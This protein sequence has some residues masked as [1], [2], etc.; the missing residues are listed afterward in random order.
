MWPETSRL[1]ILMFPLSHR[2]P[3]LAFRTLQTHVIDLLSFWITNQEITSTRVPGNS[4]PE[5]KWLPLFL[6]NVCSSGTTMMEASVGK[7][8]RQPWED[9]PLSLLITSVPLF[10][11]VPSLEGLAPTRLPSIKSHSSFKA[12]LKCHF[13][14]EAFPNLPVRINCLLLN[15]P[16]VLIISISWN[17][18][19]Y[20]L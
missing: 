1:P 18:L 19:W 11:L 5:A 8:R 16:G 12:Q 17:V 10:K 2:S 7:G 13:L 6:I 4:S 20:L 14:Q 15:V 9:G 3:T